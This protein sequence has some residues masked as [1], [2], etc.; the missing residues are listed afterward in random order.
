MVELIVEELERQGHKV[1]II[2]TKPYKKLTTSC[3]LLATKIFHLQSF[4]Y[5][6]SKIHTALR[7][8]WHIW[9]LF[10]FKTARKIEKILKKTKPDIVMTHNLKGV[11]F[12]IPRVI[13][14]LKIKHIH[15]LH[16]IQLLHPSGLLFF[17]QEKKINSIPAKVYQSINKKLFASPDLVIS[18]S[19]WL[20][21]LHTKKGFFL[22]SAQKVILNPSKKEAPLEKGAS[23][24]TGSA[25]ADRISHSYMSISNANKVSRSKKATSHVDRTGLEPVFP[26]VTNLGAYHLAERPM[27]ERLLESNYTRFLYAGQIEKHK[28]ILFLIE[29]FLEF[30]QGYPKASLTI[31][32]AGEALAKAK[33][34]AKKNQNIRFLGKLSPEDVKK[35]MRET[36]CLIAPSLCYENSPNVIREALGLEK[37]I[38][39]TDIG[40]IGE[41]LDKQ[42]LFLP[43]DKESLIAKMREAAESDFRKVKNIKIPGAKE[44]VREVLGAFK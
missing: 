1:F 7:F 32:G 22:K 14:R 25:K 34:M 44:Y 23:F 26:R 27:T 19:K 8:F 33:K 3:Q 39:A 29:A 15:T 21:D 24:N 6:L 5:N 30:N 18:P 9:D 13:Q 28:G 16:D 42:F 2:T 37:K 43:N 12:L 20:L 11:S 36:D 10:D 17:G 40:G 4:Y 31:A 41:L 38:I 35:N